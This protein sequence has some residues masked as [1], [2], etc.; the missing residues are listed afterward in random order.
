M[1]FF[2]E[3][4][5]MNFGIA[6]SMT[7]ICKPALKSG[8]NNVSYNGTV[9]GYLK[10]LSGCAALQVLES[11]LLSIKFNQIMIMKRNSLGP[12]LTINCCSPR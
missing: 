2:N 4:C 8:Q 10:A 11:K 5:T 9:L 6:L 3:L 1:E 12:D 7:H